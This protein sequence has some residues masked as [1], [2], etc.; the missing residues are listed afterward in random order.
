M[1]AATAARRVLSATGGIA[2]LGVAGIAY[3]YVESKLFTTRHVT[4]PVLPP[5]ERDIRVLHFSDLH[6]TPTQRRKLDWVRSLASLEP[7]L[8]VD[9]GDNLAH[10]DVVGPLLDA[11]APL[12]ERPGVYVMG[13]NDYWAPQ[14]KNP[15]RYLLPDSR[16]IHRQPVPLPWGR[17]TAAFDDAGWKDLDNRRDDVVLADG[18]RLSLVGTDDAHLELDQIPSR[19]AGSG[20]AGPTVDGAVLHIGVTH[21]PYQRVLRGFQDDGA[22]LILAGHTHGGQLCVPGFGALVTNCDLDRRRASG[23]HGWPGA[24]PDSPLGRGSTWLHVSAGAG[25]SPYTPVRFA[26]R[27]SATLLTLTARP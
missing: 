17:L 7:D 3:A 4:V 9:T 5:G 25:T 26:C 21:A 19:P 8:V 15:A 18:R 6:A 13:S 2:A 22:E 24:R 11:L 1:S 23:L 12:L 16:V 20:A 14:R 27:P 10:L